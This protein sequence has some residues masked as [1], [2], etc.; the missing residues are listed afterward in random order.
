MQP[1]GA[2]E[3]D[4]GVLQVD[5]AVGIEAIVG[6]PLVAQQAVA[7]QSGVG[8]DPVVTRVVE[9]LVEEVSEQQ[10]RVH[11]RRGVVERVAG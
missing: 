4:G 7:A 3:G 8:A 2:A 10:L 1:A 11:V 5:R 9:E 6:A